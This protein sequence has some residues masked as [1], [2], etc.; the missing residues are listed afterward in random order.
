MTFPEPPWTQ[1][2]SE[3]LAWRTSVG[4]RRRALRPHR[5]TRVAEFEGSLS[6]P[7][8]ARLL[9][10]MTRLGLRPVGPG[11]I[12]LPHLVLRLAHPA[13]PEVFAGRLQGTRVQVRLRKG[14]QLEA[15]VSFMPPIRFRKA[16]RLIADLG[17]H[18]RDGVWV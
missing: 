16:W 3:V 2:P 5:P 8:E 1:A 4:G 14:R 7:G 12:H 9:S 15:R 10:R 13:R 18:P 17:L 6:I 11:R